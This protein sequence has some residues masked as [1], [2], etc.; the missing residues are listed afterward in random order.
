MLKLTLTTNREPNIHHHL[1]IWW[2]LVLRR[3][4]FIFSNQPIKHGKFEAT[5][6]RPD[7]CLPWSFSSECFQRLFICSTLESWLN[8][9]KHKL[10]ETKR[11]ICYLTI[12]VTDSE[13]CWI[14]SWGHLFVWSVMNGNPTTHFNFARSSTFWHICHFPRSNSWILMKKR[15]NWY[16]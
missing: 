4:L 13:W 7:L 6:S 11:S 2:F 8:D 9:L 16:L 15:H 12:C 14:C 10:L 5:Y 1:L 3:F